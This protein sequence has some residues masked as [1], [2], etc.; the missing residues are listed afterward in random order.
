MKIEVGGEIVEVPD[1]AKWIARDKDGL[2]FVFEEQPQAVSSS[3]EW[4]REGSKYKHVS[5]KHEPLTRWTKTLRAVVPVDSPVTMKLELD[6]LL[7]DRDH[8]GKMLFGTDQPSPTAPDFLAKALG[9][10][11]D[12]AATYDKP[13]GERSMAKTVEIFNSFH[14]TTL[15]EA[16]GWHLMQIL[17]DVRLFARSGCHMDSVEDCVAYAALKGEAKAK[18]QAA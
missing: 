14:G 7:S 15:T 1:W 2:V 13:E 8:V 18:E 6:P 16:Q 3:G 11:Q 9:H 17:K 10:M 4:F 5:A 12:R